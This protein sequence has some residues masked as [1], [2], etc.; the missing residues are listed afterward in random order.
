MNMRPGQ[1]DIHTS[2]VGGSGQEGTCNSINCSIIMPDTY[3]GE[4]GTR[5]DQW[6][7][8]F[9]SVAQLNSW[10]KPTR[11]LWVQ[12]TLTGKAQAAC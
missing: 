5:W 10:D 11:L 4:L 7:I 8:H 12:M 3:K 9:D 1:V 6:I 2:D